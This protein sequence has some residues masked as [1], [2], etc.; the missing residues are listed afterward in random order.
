MDKKTYV[1]PGMPE[2]DMSGRQ[3]S[4]FEFWPSWAMY[5][6]VV[7]Q[8]L[9]MAVRYRSLT[10]PLIANPE[11]PLSG[12]VG[13]EKSRLLSRANEASQRYILDW[14]VHEKTA[15]LASDQL[16]HIETDLERHQ[17]TYPMVVKPDVGCRGSGV[18][19]VKSREALAETLDQ[20]P[21]GG[22]LMFQ[23]LSSWEPEAGVFYVRKPSEPKGQ[24][25]SL[26]LKYS[27]YVVGDGSSTLKE[28]IE[29]DSRAGQVSHLYFERHQDRLA[30]IIPKD[31]PYKLVF[32][33]SHCRGAIFRDAADHI[34]EALTDKI[35]EILKGLP[36]FYY[37]RLD[38]KFKDIE[39]LR[40]GETLEIVE[41]NSAS[42]ESLHIWDRN[43][44]FNEAVRSL[45]YQYRTLFQLG[46]ENR[47]RGYKTPKLRSL[48]S[49]W[50]KE[51]ELTRCYPS[52]D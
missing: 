52:T 43:T 3:T 29:R 26:A 12:M 50:K 42:S 28:L 1:A 23:Q 22:R 41:I 39:S 11:L 33:A 48:L 31:E 10:L 16:S 49:A 8:S 45:L 46:A 21:I 35:D 30:E 44:R 6:P 17:M 25:V 34:T 38:V 19:L 27:P 14:F 13:V 32:S 36:E 7:V 37:G 5:L 2:L 51:R 20:Y 40:A 24:I 47:Q 4:F 18:R 15:A 9:A